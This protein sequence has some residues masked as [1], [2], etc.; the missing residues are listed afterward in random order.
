L[1]TGVDGQLAS[2]WSRARRRLIKAVR[3]ADRDRF[4]ALVTGLLELAAGGQPPADPVATQRRQGLLRVGVGTASALAR[5]ACDDLELLAAGAVLPWFDDALL[6]SRARLMAAPGPPGW[7]AAML[8]AMAPVGARSMR[9]AGSGDRS[10]Y[11]RQLA[12]LPPLLR[13]AVMQERHLAAGVPEVG[14]L[15]FASAR[16]FGQ[17]ELATLV[18]GIPAQLVPPAAAPAGPPGPP[19]APLV[20]AVPPVGS[21]AEAVALVREH[22][23]QPFG[24]YRLVADGDPGFLTDAQELVYQVRW[25][26]RAEAIRPLGPPVS[27]PGDPEPV[28]YREPGWLVDRVSREVHPVDLSI[29]ELAAYVSARRVFPLPPGWR[30]GARPPLPTGLAEQVA[31]LFPEPMPGAPGTIPDEVAARYS[32]RLAT[33]GWP[34]YLVAWRVAG[35]TV[36]VLAEAGLAGPEVL[37]ATVLAARGPAAGDTLL[38]PGSPHWRTPAGELARAARPADDELDGP[39]A[40]RRAHRISTATPSAR[41]L[42]IAN[43]RARGLVER[44]LF[45]VTPQ[46]RRDELAA[47]A[48]ISRDL[49]APLRQ[50]LPAG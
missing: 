15:A 33:G 32:A 11:L 3:R 31:A 35:Q 37:T 5:L 18:P 48:D 42:A 6:G 44:E 38:D 27:N 30:P 20:L 45:G 50:D 12:A 9:A 16:P 46:A 4:D 1:V 10:G 43:A 13:A 14:R 47:L 24:G 49:P 23:H 8:L 21:P 17:A 28:R 19:G 39:G 25:N 2:D 26:A 40:A 41:A 29:G 34:D 22:L 36:A 7:T